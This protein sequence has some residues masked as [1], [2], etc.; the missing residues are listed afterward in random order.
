MMKKIAGLLP[1]FAVLAGILILAYPVAG[2]YL[3]EKNASRAQ[4]NYEAAV[5]DMGD[6]A[7]RTVLELSLIHI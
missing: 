1:V 7:R 2:N 6:E 4:G 3:N 5:Q